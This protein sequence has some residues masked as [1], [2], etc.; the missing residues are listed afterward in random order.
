MAD[1]RVV[2]FR[3]MVT[4]IGAAVSCFLLGEHDDVR[5][6]LNC[7]ERQTKVETGT[8]FRNWV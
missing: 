2:A 6:F 4:V 1:G 3:Q 7:S 5:R 8:N